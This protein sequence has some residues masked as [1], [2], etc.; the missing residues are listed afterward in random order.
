M[1]EYIR[2]TIVK[3]VVTKCSQKTSRSAGTLCIY[4]DRDFTLTKFRDN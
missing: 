4:F 1:D 2:I 3:T